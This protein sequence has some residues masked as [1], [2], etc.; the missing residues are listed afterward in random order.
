MSWSGYRRL[1]WVQCA[2]N[3]SQDSSQYTQLKRKHTSC[4]KLRDTSST[5]ILEQLKQT[6]RMIESTVLIKP[7]WNIG[8]AS[9][10]WP[11]WPGHSAIP[12]MHVS[13]L[14]F[15]ST[16]PIRGSLSP[17]VFSF[18]FSIISADSICATDICLCKDTQR[19]KFTVTKRPLNLSRQC[20]CANISSIEA[21]PDKA[22]IKLN[23]SGA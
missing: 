21:E 22:T 17:P 5:R 8:L 23:F 4:V 3:W 6:Q 11:K 1:L 2:S 10:R 13:H 20:K 14:I 9:S 18:P 15:R 12:A 19:C 16:V 7:M